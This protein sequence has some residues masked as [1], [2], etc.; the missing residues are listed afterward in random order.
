MADR[1]QLHTTDFEEAWEMYSGHSLT[2]VEGAPVYNEL[3]MRNFRQVFMAGGAMS[4]GVLSNRLSKLPGTV[5]PS[6]M[7]QALIDTLHQSLA[8]L[9][10]KTGIH[11]KGSA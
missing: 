9:E 2:D 8:E 3:W 7:I 6:Q 4:I 1:F 10:K 5:E 11:H